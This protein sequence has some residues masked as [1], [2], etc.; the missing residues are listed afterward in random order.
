MTKYV[1]YTEDFQFNTSKFKTVEDA[2]NNLNDYDNKPVAVF[3]T[4][5]EALKALEQFEVCTSQGRNSTSA[6]VA[7]VS[8]EDG[9]FDE[10]GNW[11]CWSG[12]SYSDLKCEPLVDEDEEDEEEDED[13]DEEEDERKDLTTQI[14]SEVFGID[15]NHEN[16]NSFVKAVIINFGDERGD[17]VVENDNFGTSEKYASFTNGKKKAGLH[18]LQIVFSG[19]ED[20]KLSGDRYI[21]ADDEVCFF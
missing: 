9:E 10:D 2:Y 13:E 19:I 4:A 11:E 5:E 17:I 12:G 15:E 18:P 21:N 1:L 3:D 14:Y 8:E 16:V 6:T 20:A 7:F